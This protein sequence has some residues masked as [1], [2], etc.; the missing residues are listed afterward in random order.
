MEYKIKAH[1]TRYGAPPPLR[2]EIIDQMK[3]VIDCVDQRAR[4]MNDRWGHGRL[5]SLVSIE[6]AE[7][8]RR[9]RRKF[10]H[11]VYDSD[12]DEVSKHG[13]AMMRGL[14]KLDELAVAEHGEPRPVDQW[15]FEGPSG[16]VILVKDIRDVGRAQT[17]GR[18][19]AIWSLDEIANVITAHPILDAAKH[20]F[21]GATIEEIDTGKT[22]RAKLDDDLMDLPF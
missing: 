22:V 19:A 4:M 1:P 15:E 16:L 13:D 10:Q 6:W 18:A 21:P 12:I 7:K 8:F 5:P 20:A 14:V 11:A 3:V 2:H 17:N 9:A